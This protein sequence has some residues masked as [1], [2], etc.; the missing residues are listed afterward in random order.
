VG[1]FAFIG[2]CAAVPT[3]VIPYGSAIGNHAHLAGLNLIGL[4]R[5]GVSRDAIHDLRAAYRI[6]F[7]GEGAFRD[8]V[9][10]VDRD[11]AARPEVQRIIAFIR[12]GAER[13]LMAP[14]R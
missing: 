4:K 14:A 3:D 7:A 11:F 13:P 2:G 6:L 8:R 9:A 5:R 1:A 10:Q 12:S